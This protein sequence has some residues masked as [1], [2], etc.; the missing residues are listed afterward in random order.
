[1]IKF[2]SFDLHNNAGTYIQ[3]WS[4]SLIKTAEYSA[5][6]KTRLSNLEKKAEKTYVLVN[7]MGAG[8]FWGANRN[9][10][11]FPDEPL[12]RDHKTFEKLGHAYKHH[13]FIGTTLVNMDNGKRLPIKEVT[14]GNK[15]LSDNQEITEVKKIYTRQYK[16]SVLELKLR[17]KL[18]TITVTPDH[19]ILV[20]PRNEIHCEH[21]YSRNTGNFK[22]HFKKCKKEMG[23]PVWKSAEQLVAGDYLLT[24]IKQFGTIVL[25]PAFA[26][27]IGWVAS[28]GCLGT[29]N[30]SIQFTF[31][32]DNVAD[33]E[34]VKQCLLEVGIIPR[35]YI[36]DKTN[37][38]LISNT[39][40]ILHAQLSE[41]IVGKKENKR[42]TEK[43]YALDQESLLYI[44]GAY[45]SGDGH[46]PTTGKNIGQLRIRSCSKQMLYML[47]DLINMFNMPTTINW[48]T[49]SCIF[50]V[51]GGKEYVS[52]GSG[53][54]AVESQYSKNLVKYS[55]KKNIRVNVHRKFNRIYKN[56]IL[57]KIQTINEKVISE[58]VYNLETNSHSYLI[59][60]SV[61]HNCNKDPEKSFGQV[62]IAVF[63]P[64]MHRVELVLELDNQ[65]AKEVLGRIEK[66][67]YPAVSMG[68]K[69]PHDTCSIC[70]KKSKKVSN[71]C[72]HLR[73][74]M[75]LTLS[76]GRKVYA[77]NDTD[78]K[79][80][81]IS[82]VRIPA[83]RTASV[84]AKV[85]S[86]QPEIPSA[87]IAQEFLK[88]SG[89][90][91]SAI[92]KIIDGTIASVD[93]DPKRLIYASQQPIPKE[94]LKEVLDKYS[95][96]EIFSTM[97]GMR[98]MPT[99][100]EFQYMVLS[101]GGKEDLAKTAEAE[102]RLLM[103][104]EEDPEI[105]ADVNY[106]NF[107]DELAQKIAHWAPGI[108]LTIPHVIK[109]VLVKR[110][111]LASS[112][113]VAITI[114]PGIHAPTLKRPEDSVYNPTKNPLV[115][116]L[117]LGALYIGYNALMSNVGL[118]EKSV[119]TGGAF[120]KFLLSKPWLIPIVLGA[121]AAGTVGVQELMFNKTAAVVRPHFLKRLLVS[122]PAS[123]V[124]A[125]SQE[126][127]LQQGQP[128]TEFG[129]F[130]RR[131]P[132]LA[133]ATGTFALG[134]MHKL[135]KMKPIGTE[136]AKTA[137]IDIIDRLILGLEPNKLE[138]FYND[139]I[140]FKPIDIK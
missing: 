15:V 138:L 18:N 106:N 78:L 72:E 7:A 61:V 104:I 45:I 67:D 11:Y 135:M 43:I 59:E 128:I 98:M 101:K 99:P 84:L 60:D 51:G 62:K 30:K 19:P 36:V 22:C 140:D 95:S 42:F 126:A 37:C 46:I 55:R 66:G 10:D 25:P 94:E 21:G 108:S 122:V 68:V 118:G 136:L 50:T 133:G 105:P 1:M 137:E 76:D 71:Y 80:F 23:S 70:G 77:I 115:P 3:F 119:A 107:N 27:L 89:I 33:I 29:N 16:G 88:A 8:E 58:P 13:C 103:D 112:T 129:D 38:V 52:S 102:G 63:N 124:Y 74:Q 12:A 85:A 130:I 54:V 31:A 2:T 139:V 97:L 123:Y 48:D 93:N 91:E 73:N 53:C 47:S 32:K 125:G 120:E 6:L 114:N 64:D 26:K 5:E 96:A 87:V 44:L 79:F 4:D 49:P 41:Y 92:N 14:A 81:D 127:K 39:S 69:V 117:G 57:N 24:P 9:G 82:F 20:F 35:T 100:M 116:L 17:G 110:A 65:R 113:P 131:H 34:A 132:F 75:G 90:K 28:E 134:Q 109:R 86:V 40:K 83:D 111:E 121:A 56:Y